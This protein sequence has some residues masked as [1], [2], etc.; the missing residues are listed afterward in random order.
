M[1]TMGL[2]WLSIR[3]VTLAVSQPCYEVRLLWGSAITSLEFQISKVE[4]NARDFEG[5]L[6]AASDL[7]HA[8]DP[9]LHHDLPGKCKLYCIL[10]KPF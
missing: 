1:G 2:I 10:S 9:Q 7:D 3:T 6:K 8:F 5:A 4:E